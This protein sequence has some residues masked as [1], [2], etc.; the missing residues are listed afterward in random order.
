MVIFGKISEEKEISK[1]WRSKR[2]L[3]I[4]LSKI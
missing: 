1:G 4:K 2:N 3:E